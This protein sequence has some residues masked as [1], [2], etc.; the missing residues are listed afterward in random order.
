M[1]KIKVKLFFWRKSLAEFVSQLEIQISENLVPQRKIDIFL[2]LIQQ[3]QLEN[4]IKPL[5]S[6]VFW[7]IS[8]ISRGHL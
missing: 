8:R 1:L 5:V 7:L 3:L 4:S 2:G 6:C